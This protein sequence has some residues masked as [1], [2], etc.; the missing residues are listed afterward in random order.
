MFKLFKRIICY[1]IFITVLSGNIIALKNTVYAEG[2]QNYGETTTY[3]NGS[4]ENLKNIS[5]DEIVEFLD[6]YINKKMKELNVP[7]L[8]ISAIRNNKEIFNKVIKVMDMQI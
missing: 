3:A 4:S 7:G 2:T 6:T 1:L 8:A 5:D